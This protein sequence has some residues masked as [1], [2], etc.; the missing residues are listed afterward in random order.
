MTYWGPDTLAWAALGVGH[1]DFV[2]WAAA[3][4]LAEFY[5]DLRWPGWER[6]V[7]PLP[8][9]AGLSVYPPPFTDEGRDLS[10]TSRRAVPMTELLNLY[11]D[12]AEQLKGLAPGA[13]FKVKPTE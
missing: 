7:A 11:Q 13:V 1:T 9:S 4:G 12:F 8:A 5:A 3:G 2:H 6:E 10:S